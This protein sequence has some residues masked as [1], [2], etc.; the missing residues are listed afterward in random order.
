[1]KIGWIGCG[2]MGRPMAT[3][4]I[5]AGHQVT[6]FDVSKDNIEL[7]KERGAVITDSPKAVTSSSDF[8][9]TM[10]PNGKILEDV[11]LNIETGIINELSSEKV[12][13][14]M[15]TVAPSE[16]EMIYNALIKT[17][18][19]YLR[20]PVT[21]STVLAEKSELGIFASG[22]KETYDKVLPLFKF[23]GNNFHYLGDGEQSRVLKLAINLMIAINLQMLAESITLI[24]K[25]GIDRKQ[26]MEIIGKSAAGSPVI[27]YKT[28]NI[29]NCDYKPAFSVA[30]MEK[31]L[32]LVL[33][34][35]K[36]YNLGLPLTSLTRQF[37]GMIHG[38]GN[39]DKDFS[40]LVEFLEKTY[41]L[42]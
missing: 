39:Q 12:F 29:I 8:I 40:Y 24:D 36:D 37:L 31:D 14:D 21:G 18:T 42:K 33:A 34:T 19:E 1:M 16:S 32:D 20:A 27:N 41:S 9:F 17:G 7:M 23:I 25:S 35:A 26:A 30:M 5:K 2:N 28:D 11:V 13:I 6:V 15:S 3:N 10:L 38:S 22:K 4:L